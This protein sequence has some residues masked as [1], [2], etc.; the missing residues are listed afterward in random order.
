MQAGADYLI[1][2]HDFKSFCLAKSANN[3]PTCRYIAEISFEKMNIF[4]DEI[5]AMSIEGNAFLHSMVRTIAGSLVTI[6]KGKRASSWMSEVLNAQDRRAA[7]E[8]APAKGLVFW[9]V[10]Y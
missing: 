4:E 3:K 1:G 10:V 8:C 9:E 6:G 2:E 7:G 5:L